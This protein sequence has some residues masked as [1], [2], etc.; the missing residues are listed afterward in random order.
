VSP[1]F[2]PREG[3][4]AQRGHREK[5]GRV[6]GPAP[7]PT[8]WSG[9]FFRLLVFWSAGAT[10]NFPQLLYPG[11]LKLWSCPHQPIATHTLGCPPGCVQTT[12]SVA[13]LPEV[14]RRTM[15]L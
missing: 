13:G 12:V 4:R 9:S 7:T 8:I 5:P 11:V 14:W 1:D 2:G 6:G 10:Q 3:A 15:G